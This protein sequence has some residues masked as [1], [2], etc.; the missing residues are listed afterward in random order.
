MKR[1]LFILILAWCSAAVWAQTPNIRSSSKVIVGGAY[2]Y[3]HTVQPGE[4]LSSLGRT[5]DTTPDEIIKS[6]PATAEGLQAGQVIKI[7]APAPQPV[8]E[9]FL[10]KVTSNRKVTVHIAN[11][12]ETAYSI[13]KRYAIS[14][15]NLIEVNP[16]FD[17]AH[18]QVG[19]KI[20]IPREMIGSSTQTEIQRN[21]NQYTEALAGLTPGV[22]HHLV[23]K[24]ETLYSLSKALN[25]SID[26]LKAYNPAELADGLKFGSLIKYPVANGTGAAVRSEATPAVQKQ[27]GNVNGSA[28]NAHVTT[29]GTAVQGDAAEA[30]RGT[31]AYE[32][33][34]TKDF[35]TSAPLNVTMMLPFKT[36]ASEER[37]F[38]E[39]YNGALLALEDLK[40]AGVS[41]DLYV[42][43]TQKS[44]N[45]VQEILRKDGI[46]KTDLII[47]PVYEAAFTEAAEF[48]YKNRIPIVSPL[49]PI[50]SGN[51]FVYQATPAQ[52]HKYDKLKKMLSSGKN[53]IMITPATGL[54]AEFKA[55]I[56]EI[57]P[58]NTQH[59]SYSKGMS[60]AVIEKALSMD[61]DNLIVLPTSNE[62]VTEEI[63]AKI[64]SIQ[65]AVIATSGR[66]YLISTLGSPRWARFKTIDKQYFFKLGATYITSYHADR[67]NP[68]VMQFDNRYIAT[69]NTL[70][71]LYAYRG[72]DVTKI[73]VSAIKEYGNR[74]SNSI[75]RVNPGLL[76]VP[77]HFERDKEGKWAN[78]QWVLI[79][80][81]NDYLIDVE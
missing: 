10:D 16:G 34:P 56:S 74:F 54:D 79:R 40:Q 30:A 4:T 25:V 18:I 32:T 21:F 31:A 81:R 2:Y 47:G 52:E 44:G 73:F 80:Y 17:P 61:K 29:A 5:Y 75:N 51:P 43:N 72:Y 57:L 36:G 70:P 38:V 65:N 69:F 50:S 78:D 27:A 58:H 41:V 24:G 37:N 28:G 42:Y 1:I 15:D 49:A 48:A 33:V 60:S 8:K 45:E 13:A 14:V 53:V 19:Q 39:F 20:A 66:S 46:R 55:E 67:S 6:N 62:N 76:Q 77:Y 22:G 9:G 63:M 64:S 59:I 35:N 12:G 26:T 11:Q 68:A 71:S 7:P 23:E 3:V